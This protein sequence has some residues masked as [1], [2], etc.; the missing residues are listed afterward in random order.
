MKRIR[1]GKTLFV[2]LMALSLLASQQLCAAEAFLSNSFPKSAPANT[3]SPEHH[4][5]DSS[6]GHDHQQSHQHDS[7][8]SESCC[9]Q[10]SP[11]L[12]SLDNGSSLH[13]L[14]TALILPV[15]WLIAN[16]S[17]AV[18]HVLVFRLN[19]RHPPPELASRISLL[20]LSLSPN[21][22]PISISN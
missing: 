12:L 14:I 22:P 7:S 13:K 2:V 17:F 21:A 6:A 1:L 10:Q 4:K 20:S 11:L 5:H 18:K 19:T 9:E 16:T 8:S 3:T 15:S